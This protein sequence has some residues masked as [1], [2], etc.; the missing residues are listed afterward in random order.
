MTVAASPPHS[1]LIDA[2]VHVW[3]PARLTYPWLDDLPVLNRAFLPGD[4]DREHGAAGR[5]VFV[6]AGCLPGRAIDEVRWVL[7]MTDAWPELA[8]IVADADLRGGA[9]LESHLDELLALNAANRRTTGGS[10]TGG[11]TTGGS[12]TGGSTT[13]GST[14]GEST[15]DENTTGRSTTSESTAGRAAA[16]QRTVRRVRVAGV[17]HLLQDEPDD[18]LTDP[19]S[20]AALLD[21][22]RALAARGLTFDVCVRHRQLNTVI[23][24]LEQVPQLPTVLDHLGKPSVDD[25]IESDP[26][27]AWARAITRLA[28]LPRA[29]VKLS[30][31]AAEASGTDALDA[32]AEGFLGHALRAFGPDRAM[33][34]SDWP[35]SA[36]TGARGTFD[37]WRH[38]VRRAAATADVDARGV[39]SIEHGTATQFYGLH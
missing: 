2:H 32:H 34:G 4:F 3:D 17:R 37:G 19:R 12:T 28:R 1:A 18:L 11:S 25:G 21:G 22:L 39:A 14:T 7:G 16:G 36:L 38:R 24:L 8:A 29:R 15:T 30:G 31:L 5:H 10:T 33:V 6:Q 9:A 23:D 13:G 35:V 20:R 27:R 26:G